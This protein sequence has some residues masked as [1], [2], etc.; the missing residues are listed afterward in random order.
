M[1]IMKALF[2][3][4]TLVICSLAHPLSSASLSKEDMVREAAGMVEAGLLQAASLGVVQKGV[5]TT[6]HVGILAPDQG[7]APDDE[8]VYEI[9]SISKVFT[10]LLLA[11]AVVRGE[12][13]LE[14]PIASLL[15]AD[16]ELPD[17]V[18][19]RITLLMLA[20][21]TS[22]LPRIPVEIPAD[23][24]TN[25]YATYDDAALW[26]TLRTV[27]LDFP[28]GTKAGYSNLAAGLLGTLLA[29]KA[30][31]TYAQLLVT[32][33]AQPLG[34]THTAIDVDETLRPHVAPPFSAAGEP[35]SPWDFQALAGAG[36]IRSSIAD[37][38]RFAA[39]II[40]PSETPLKEAIELAWAR[41]EL[42]AT[43]F[44][45]GQALGWMVAGDGRTRWHN[46]M[47]GGFHA[48]LFV[49]RELGMASVVLANRSSPAGTELAE[50][51]VRRA[52]GLPERPVPNRDRP[53][54][55][56]S[57]EQLDRCV[58]TYRISPEFALV[59]ERRNEALFLTPTGQGTDRLYAA[60][61]DTFFSRR[62]PAD[63]V[64]T[65]PDGG[66]PAMGLILKQGGREIPAVRE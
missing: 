21:H 14:T 20:T 2:C 47:T 30:E 8:T 18:G 54:V 38:V 49:N 63:I 11:E 1:T 59:F 66:G 48:A 53:Q 23:D 16:V 37:M 33:I 9:G 27:K 58:G 24:Y 61:P 43:V 42:A 62:V 22:G 12:V 52:A 10:G 13:T 44:P 46:G 28:P 57:F 34:M 17:G 29:R 45:G 60:G 50:G 55:A 65:F 31:M 32:R 15:P 56:L 35:W 36:G 4:T 5:V 25:P 41:Q 3:R 39:A 7:K 6:A 51:L 19:D 26:A 40:Q 64:F